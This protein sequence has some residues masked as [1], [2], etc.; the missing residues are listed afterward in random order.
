MLLHGV[1][2]RGETLRPSPP[3]GKK[4][5]AEPPSASSGGGGAGLSHHAEIHSLL[6]G[7]RPRSTSRS[8]SAS[9]R[10]GGGG[11]A[12]SSPA[13]SRPRRASR[14][15]GE[16]DGGAPPARP[17]RSST[18][19]A[20]EHEA[21][22]LPPLSPPLSPPSLPVGAS[23][24]SLQKQSRREARGQSLSRRLLRRGRS[25]QPRRPGR[26][27]IDGDGGSVGGSRS[28]TSHKSAAASSAAAAMRSLSPSHFRYR[29]RETTRDEF[30]AGGAAPAAAY[31]K[32]GSDPL[33]Y[34]E[35]EGDD[36]VASARERNHRSDPVL[37]AFR[38]SS[39]VARGTDPP[40]D[41][42]EAVRVPASPGAAA[43]PPN[44]PTPPQQRTR[45][46]R[47]DPR[48]S[49]LKASQTLSSASDGEPEEEESP[50][51][52]SSASKPSK[53]K[54]L[55]KVVTKGWKRGPK[56]SATSRKE[57][58]GRGSVEGAGAVERKHSDGAGVAVVQ[59]G[60]SHGSGE[61]GRTEGSKGQRSIDSNIFSR[62]S[63]SAKPVP[64]RTKC[65]TS[66]LPC[67]SNRV[68]ISSRALGPRPE[69]RATRRR[70]RPREGL[71]PLRQPLRFVFR[72]DGFRVRSGRR[73]RCDSS[74]V[75]DDDDVP[76]EPYPGL[77]DVG[78]ELVECEAMRRSAACA[79]S[80]A[81]SHGRALKESMCLERIDFAPN[82]SAGSG[83]GT[84]TTTSS[85]Q[86]PPSPTAFSHPDDSLRDGA[87]V[88][89]DEDAVP[90]APTMS[91]LVKTG[92]LDCIES[93]EDGEVDDGGGSVDPEEAGGGP[94]GGAGGEGEENLGRSQRDL[95]AS[96]RSGNDRSARLEGSGTNPS[97]RVDGSGSIGSNFLR[98]GGSIG[99]GSG[100]RISAEPVDSSGSDRSAGLDNLEVFG[101]NAKV[102]RGGNV[103][104]FSSSSD[105]NLLETSSQMT[106]KSSMSGKS[107]KSGRTGASLS[108]RNDGS[109]SNRS[110][111][112]GV[113]T[114]DEERALSPTRSRSGSGR[115]ST[116]TGYDV[117]DFMDV[118][119]GEGGRGGAGEANPGGIDE[120]FRHVANSYMDSMART[121]T[122]DMRSKADES[123][124]S[125]E[126][127]VY[128]GTPKQRKKASNV[129]EGGD[130]R[131][132]GGRN[133][134][135]E[136]R[137]SNL[138]IRNI[139]RRGR[140]RGRT[141]KN[142][143]SSPSNAAVSSPKEKEGAESD[144]LEISDLS[145]KEEAS[146]AASASDSKDGRS[147]SLFRRRHI[148][149]LRKGTSKERD[150]PAAPRRGSSA[151]V[152]EHRYDDDGRRDARRREAQS[153][154]RKPSISNP[155]VKA[156]SID[157]SARSSL[158]Y[159]DLSSRGGRRPRRRKCLVCRTKIPRG[160]ELRCMDFAFC[161]ADC[162]RCSSCKRS[163][164]HPDRELG[165]GDVSSTG[166]QV[167]SNA[168]GSV[169][170]CGECARTVRGLPAVPVIDEE[171]E[172]RDSALRQSIHLD[173]SDRYDDEESR[174]SGP[175]T[176]SGVDRACGAR[177]ARAAKGLAEKASVELTVIATSGRSS[178]NRRLSKLYFMQSEEGNLQA[179]QC[180]VASSAAQDPSDAPTKIFYELDSDAH[181]NP[182]YDGY[183]CSFT[184]TNEEDDGPSRQVSVELPK[185]ESDE[186]N[187]AISQQLE[188]DFR[189]VDEDEDSSPDIHG[190]PCSP[191]RS[192]PAMLSIEPFRSTTI[193]KETVMKVLRQTWEYELDGVLHKLTLVVPFKKIYISWEIDEGD[194]LDLTQ[195][196]L[197]VTLRC[198]DLLEAGQSEPT[199]GLSGLDTDAAN[200]VTNTVR[201][202]V[203]EYERDDD[204][205]DGFTEN[206]SMPNAVF[207]KAISIESTVTDAGVRSSSLVQPHQK[208]VLD[209]DRDENDNF[210]ELLSVAGCVNSVIALPNIGYVKV[211]KEDF[212]CEVGLSLID[213]NGATV[214]A[215]VSRSGLFANTPVKE[216]CEILAINGH[217]VRGP[218]SVMRIMK[219]IAG[220][221][222]VMVSDGP[223][224]PGARIVVQRHGLA[225]FNAILSQDDISFDTVDGL[226]RV[227]HVAKDGIFGKSD[228]SKGDICLSVD[229]VPTVSDAIA[230]RTLGRS[231][232]IVA[233]MVF[234]LR[235]FWRSVVEFTIDE[236]YNRWWRKDT[237]C[238]LLWGSEDC[239]PITLLF[240]ERTGLCRAAGNEEND[241]DLKYTNIILE[242]VMRLFRA[243]IDSYRTK[244]KDHVRESSRS[245]SVTPS[246]KMK[247]RSD[248]YRR[249]LIKLDEMR[250][251]GM[252]SAEDYEAGRH[253]LAQVAIQTTK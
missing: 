91:M 99:S 7:R 169:V 219:D 202:D 20:P 114:I 101:R 142:D 206:G 138:S 199:M 167:V 30:V 46:R 65:A 37:P 90:W 211:K 71:A 212:E 210:S 155:D 19:P 10:I 39:N 163:L 237:E 53:S 207:V 203:V 178:E 47:A 243:S 136:K 180:S 116:G 87:H 205:T 156:A 191:Q 187:G 34:A 213:K 170:Q 84:L 5:V 235:G 28:A 236:K 131:G 33:A 14:E 147:R 117:D 3:S 79:R 141:R 194:E 76:A 100:L 217:C 61:S 241:I 244:P 220:K 66:K 43:S 104:N 124:L 251:N 27:A 97:S 195:S 21:A 96:D 17:S 157:D 173:E 135:P 108:L 230:A 32:R 209:P 247:N 93:D 204:V 239:T 143:P 151:G 252:L 24:S 105:M 240:D 222:L 242:R 123:T 179:R 218:R 225:G 181:G 102:D 197:E 238:S 232:S 233:I 67:H 145:E 193:S 86:S 221:V 50:P 70:R 165:E 77:G 152:A 226:V 92:Q 161:S 153:V 196:Q 174:A 215:E 166:L 129:K 140:S 107:S 164:K 59:S 69:S 81:I 56:D 231:Q 25:Q 144:Q 126:D 49:S 18:N 201:E 26:H 182:N 127:T 119:E 128:S 74:F 112:P 214:V 16:G 111:L 115:S 250:E 160:K 120:Y 58:A 200:P 130:R 139:V 192:G 186:I 29:G 121:I 150:A 216:G 158:E 109:D 133:A 60:N 38:R 13:P 22:P 35:K 64:G 98:P 249:A 134:S 177:L 188:V 57:F 132:G 253:A 82:V 122:C 1:N 95:G 48:P 198:D 118:P 11:G 183:L 224:P 62:T 229:G 208:G 227:R 42:A 89:E 94:E 2:K 149:I 15:E 36:S 4:S 125:K 162:F 85:S 159:S 6:R 52:S 103:Y 171:S 73:C 63:A 146:V 228:I 172:L 137:K 80:V 223:S 45:R 113:P 23:A 176:S 234:S 154:P 40:V 189:W 184:E 190:G 110:G 83:D 246:G 51:P 175:S 68:R 185:L 55:W 88:L 9:R 72:R 248:V 168:R 12:L 148:H 245:L 41:R 78:R 44:P 8:V 31:A 54:K 106:G 75:V